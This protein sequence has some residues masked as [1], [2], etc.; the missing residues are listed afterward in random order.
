ML[1][2]LYF[3]QCNPVHAD[4]RD[5]VHWRWVD[6]SNVGL[7]VVQYH[8]CCLCVCSIVVYLVIKVSGTRPELE[9]NMLTGLGAQAFYISMKAVFK[10]SLS[11]G[12]RSVIYFKCTSA[13]SLYWEGVH[14]KIARSINNHLA[15]LAFP[16]PCFFFHFIDVSFILLIQAWL[17]IY[18]AL[19]TVLLTVRPTNT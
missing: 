16:S 12:N 9:G 4:L 3:Y 13:M 19:P 15:W 14:T 7:L 18:G 2:P 6:V 5:S 1:L 11:W 17:M 10:I 8:L